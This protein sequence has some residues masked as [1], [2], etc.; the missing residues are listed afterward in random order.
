[1]AKLKIASTIRPIIRA[2]LSYSEAFSWFLIIRLVEIRLGPSFNESLFCFVDLSHSCRLSQSLHHKIH[3]DRRELHAR[4][5][6]HGGKCR[7]DDVSC[8]PSTTKKVCMNQYVPLRRAF[9]TN[10][11]IFFYSSAYNFARAWNEKQPRS[12]DNGQ[13]R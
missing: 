13:S 12:L 1:M 3:I 4:E 5:M 7:N 2:K 9:Q 8:K 6:A 10:A 11:R